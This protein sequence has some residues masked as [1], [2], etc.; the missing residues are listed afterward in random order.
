MK[1]AQLA[2]LKISADLGCSLSHEPLDM[3]IHSHMKCLHAVTPPLCTAL[4]TLLPSYH[5]DGDIH[6]MSETFQY[7]FC[8]L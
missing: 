8:P 6:G 4:V 3:S 2:S 5:L 7:P 1:K